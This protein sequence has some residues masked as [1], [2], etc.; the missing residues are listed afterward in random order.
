ME[1][2]VQ[3]YR[4][5]YEELSDLLTHAVALIDAQSGY[6]PNGDREFYAERIFTKMVCHGLSLQRL[7]PS[8]PFPG[9]E[10][11]DISSSYAVARSLIETYEAL[12]YVSLEPVDEKER[13]F[14][15]LLWKLHAQERRREMLRLIGSAH[16]E[17][18]G[19]ET[20]IAALRSA[21]LGHPF[22]STL[23]PAFRGKVARGETPPYHLSRAERDARTGID[24]DYHAA[25]IMHLSAHVHTHPFSIHQLFDFRAGN[26]DCV[27]LM[28]IPLRYCSAFLG[29]AI[30]GI[31]QLFAPRVPVMPPHLLQIITNWGEV[32]SKGVKNV[33]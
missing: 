18:L 19:I 30:L 21:I 6:V 1:D 11:W 7:T 15:F 26:P 27:R 22:T 28:A 9:D 10:L 5:A 3:K 17:A 8:P 4:E 12:A 13:E 29:R 14:R 23:S 2:H 25:V 32:L 33:G 16:P 24:R 31:R 20:N